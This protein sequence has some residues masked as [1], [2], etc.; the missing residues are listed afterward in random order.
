MDR[1]VA[2]V[3]GGTRGIGLGCAEALAREGWAVAV[4]GVRAAAEAEPALARLRALGAE[5]LHVQA[6]VGDDDAPRR[7]VEA[8]DARF[9]RLDLLVNNAGVAPAERRDLLDA[10]RESFDR[11]LR[12]NL[13]G[14]YFLAQAAARYMLRGAAPAGAARSIVFVGSISATVASINRGE[15]CVS[16]AGLA[17]AS[18]VFAA[19]L[20]GE[21]IA[22]YEVRPGIIRTD[23]SAPAA[24]RYDRLIEDG[25]TAQK[26]WG[27]PE[28]V[29]RAVAMLARGELP[30]STGQVV[31]VDGGLTVQRL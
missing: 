21:G 12:V 23:M 24:E 17:M 26:R 15:Y 29:G 30:Y 20:A 13:R 31:M 6:D 9:G 28:D 11:V 4:C 25:L 8:V 7:L 5:P 22:V 3:T 1:R 16:K 14:P 19:R 2:L 27:T 10:T 18:L